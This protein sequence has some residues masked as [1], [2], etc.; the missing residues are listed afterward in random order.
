MA[1]MVRI[2]RWFH[3]SFMIEG[4]MKTVYQLAVELGSQSKAAIKLGVDR[5][6]VSRYIAD[7]KGERHHVYNGRLFTAKGSPQ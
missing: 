3:M 4:I 7:K 1:V 5:D 6:T 2:I